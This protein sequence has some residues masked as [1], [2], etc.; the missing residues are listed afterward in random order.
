MRKFFQ[1]FYCYYIYI[2]YYYHYYYHHHHHCISSFPYYY[3]DYSNN[4]NYHYTTTTTT[5]T[6]TTAATTTAMIT[7]AATVTSIVLQLSLVQCLLNIRFLQHNILEGVTCSVL[8]YKKEVNSV[9]Y[10]YLQISLPH[11]SVG[12]LNFH[13]GFE[14]FCFFM[15]ILM[16]C[17]L[18]FVS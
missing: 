8:R 5:T 7:T 3:Y 10:D 4:N 6:T 15:C 9:R 18:H 16:L 2:Y 12:L 13:L 17:S 1:F 14:L 11:T